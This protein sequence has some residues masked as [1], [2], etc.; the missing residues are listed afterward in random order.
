M[1]NLI[2]EIGINITEV[3]APDSPHN[4]YLY[5]GKRLCIRPLLMYESA[6]DRDHEEYL[7]IR[8]H[9]IILYFVVQFPHTSK[10]IPFHHN[11]S[12][13][14]KVLWINRK[15]LKDV[16]TKSDTNNCVTSF[17][18]GGTKTMRV[19]RIQFSQLEPF[20]P[21]N[22]TGE[23]LSKEDYTAYKFL[24]KRMESF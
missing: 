4:K 15:E 2:N 3:E 20:Y 9:E 13:V 10:E 7:S 8:F 24:L 1:D 23:G 22:L 17:T 19:C 18:Q 6:R 21:N 14:D 11:E 12:Q 16:L 5:K